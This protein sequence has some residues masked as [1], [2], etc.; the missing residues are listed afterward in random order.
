MLAYFYKLKRI[1]NQWQA[2]LRDTE[3]RKPNFDELRQG[4]N[5]LSQQKTQNCTEGSGM[6]LVHRNWEEVVEWDGRSDAGS[7][8]WSGRKTGAA[9]GMKHRQVALRIMTKLHLFSLSW[10]L[11]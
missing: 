6:E 7:N 5:V 10:W 8:A 1:V 3:T 9:H 4:C 11:A 2:G